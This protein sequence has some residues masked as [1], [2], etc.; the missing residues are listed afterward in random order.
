VV[1]AANRAGIYLTNSALTVKYGFSVVCRDG[2]LSAAASLAAPPTVARGC[3]LPG[4]SSGNGLKRI[5]RVV[6]VGA[7]LQR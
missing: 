3:M 7:M 6:F 1:L 2:Q 5:V 4:P